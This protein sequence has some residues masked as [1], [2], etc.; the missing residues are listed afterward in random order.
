MDYWH[1]FKYLHTKF[2]LMI[3][4]KTV[5]YWKYL[6]D[7][8]LIEVIKVIIISNGTNESHVLSDRM[9]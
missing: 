7:T 9:H 1:S 4:G 2:L 8:A 3:K 6:I 5:L